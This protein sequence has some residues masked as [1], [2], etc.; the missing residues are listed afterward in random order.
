MKHIR[1]ILASLP[2]MVAGLSASATGWPAGYE[3]VMLQAFYWDS[4]SDT[5]WSR[6][7]DQAEELSASF[8]LVWVPNSGRCGGSQSMGYMPQYWFTNHNSSFGPETALNYMIGKFRDNGVGV[9]ADVVVNHRTGVNSWTDFPAEEWNGRTWK[10]GP[11]HICSNDEVANQPGQP[12]PTGAPD[13]GENFDGARDLDHTNA[14]VQEHVKNYCKCLLE[15]YGYVGFRLDMVK[16]Y[17][18]HFTKIYNQYSKPQFCVGEY[19]DGYDA[20]ARWIEDTGRESAAFDFPCK[21]ALNEAFSSNNMTKLVWKANGTVDQPAGLI[22]FGYPQ[23]AVTFVDNHDTYRDGSKFTGNV[24]AANAFILSSPGTP[25][26]FLPHWKAHKGQI[27]K[28]IAARKAAGVSNTSSVRVLKLATNVYLAEVTG[29][30]TKLAV[31]IGS[32]SDVPA[33]Y[34][35]ADL[36]ASGTGYAI[37]VKGN[38]GGGDITEDNY[39]AQLHILG[40]LA[41]SQWNTSS[42]ALMTRAGDLYTASNVEFVAAPNETKCFFNITTSLAANW[43]ELNNTADRYGAATE[44]TPLTLGA[45][46]PVTLYACG[47]DASGCKS[48]AIAP[49]RYDLVLDIRRKTIK[50]MAAGSAGIDEINVDNSSAE[51]EYYTPA[52]VRVN[53]PEH[54]LYIVKRGSKVSKVYIR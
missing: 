4:Y 39:P 18:G 50:L 29:S 6:L 54:G 31:R 47:V 41:G 33:G 13:T 49:G 42:G 24:L 22:H 51:P 43:D 53:N 34:T 16:G 12:R 17:A 10:L 32:S 21:Y 48:W 35:S 23:Y 1:S 19:W 40:N 2:M 20:I 27:A 28:M 8:D 30:K 3:G 38:G 45:E 14:T 15:K 7:G 37:W 36:Y 5:R 25:C 44:G 46:A 9:I 52:G 26:V 11:E